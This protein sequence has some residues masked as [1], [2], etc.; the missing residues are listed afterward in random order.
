MVT[1]RIWSGWN[2]N[3]VARRGRGGSGTV[4]VVLNRVMVIWSGLEG[5]DWFRVGLE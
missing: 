2:K 4:V 3:E 1:I 5:F